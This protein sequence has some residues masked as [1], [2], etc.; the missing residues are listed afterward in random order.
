MPIG[1]DACHLM[2][3]FIDMGTGTGGVAPRHDDQDA[4]YQSVTVPAGVDGSRGGPQECASKL[5]LIDET[6][7]QHSLACQVQTVCLQCCDASLHEHMAA[8]PRPSASHARQCS[9]SQVARM[10]WSRQRCLPALLAPCFA[11]NDANLIN[12]A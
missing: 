10:V 1:P 6:A 7:A 12:P 2:H 9:N 4:E 3:L 8:G 5:T 11:H